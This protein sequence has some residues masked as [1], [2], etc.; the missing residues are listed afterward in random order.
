MYQR[1]LKVGI[2]CQS[3]AVRLWFMF[4][5]DCL[6]AL[7][8]ASE[9]VSFLSLLASLPLLQTHVQR[10]RREVVSWVAR[11]REIK[12]RP[13]LLLSSRKNAS[14][15]RKKYQR[16]RC[17]KYQKE[18]LETVRLTRKR[19]YEKRREKQF[20]EYNRRQDWLSSERKRER[21]RN[22]MS[23]TRSWR[24]KKSSKEDAE[25]A[26]ETQTQIKDWMKM[27]GCYCNT[28]SLTVSCEGWGVRQ[29][30]WVTLISREGI[31]QLQWMSYS[32]SYLLMWEEG[33]LW[34]KGWY[35]RD[36][37]GNLLFRGITVTLGTHH[38]A[39]R[40]QAPEGTRA[41]IGVYI[42]FHTFSRSP[43]LSNKWMT[44]ERYTETSIS[45]LFQIS[46]WNLIY[47]SKSRKNLEGE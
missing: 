3:Q 9:S 42:C 40:M 30:D 28:M 46:L 21:E 12:R 27:E 39:R 22:A 29:T 6:N 26:G 14:Q 23:R 24:R 38:D 1:D 43:L 31:Q 5:N 41:I 13:S 15:E 18:Q 2:Q 37:S 47:D 7:D 19:R 20:L 32:E 35:V 16:G 45:S 44:Q 17:V 36:V 25:A 11:E 10:D 4:S 8:F 34:E 33:M